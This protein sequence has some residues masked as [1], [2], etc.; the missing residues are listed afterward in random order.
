MQGGGR[1]GPEE[2]VEKPPER[3]AD[4]GRQPPRRSAA[5][6]DRHR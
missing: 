2:A 6:S 3:Q 1:P 5:G 4:R